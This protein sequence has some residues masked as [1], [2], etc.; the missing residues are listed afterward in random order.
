MR[1]CVGNTFS[2]CSNHHPGPRHRFCVEEGG[3]ILQKLPTAPRRSSLVIEQMRTRSEDIFT[4]F[5]APDEKVAIRPPQDDPLFRELGLQLRMQ[6][7]NLLAVVRAFLPQLVAEAL[8]EGDWDFV[9]EGTHIL[10]RYDGTIV[11]F[12]CV[13]FTMLSARLVTQPNG[14]L[15][16]SRCLSRFFTPLI[17]LITAYRGDV[18]KF[19]GTR[20]IAFFEAFDDNSSFK[21]ACGALSCEHKPDELAC[22]RA[23]ACCHEVNKRLHNFDVGESGVRVTLGAGVGSGIVTVLGVNCGLAASTRDLHAFLVAGAPVDQASVATEYAG[24]FD[25]VLSAQA[26]EHI[27]D[28]VVE[29]STIIE[30]PDFHRLQC[31]DVAQHTYPMIRHAAQQSY[32]PRLSPLGDLSAEDV[33]HGLVMSKNFLHHT[34]VRHVW[35]RTRSDMDEV[36]VVTSVVIRIQGIEPSRE[37]VARDLAKLLL[38]LQRAVHEEEGY[39]LKISVDRRGVLLQFAFGIPPLVHVDDAQ[40]ACRACLQMVMRIRDDLHTVNA[41]VATGHVFCGAIGSDRRCDY[42]IIGEA[43]QLAFDLSCCAKDLGTVLVDKRTRDHCGNELEFTAVDSIILTCSP[44]PALAF[45]LLPAHGEQGGL[46]ATSSGPEQLANPSPRS[47]QRAMTP[48]RAPT[49]PWLDAASTRGERKATSFLRAPMLPTLWTYL[50]VERSPFPPKSSDATVEGDLHWKTHVSVPLPWPARSVACGGVSPL[51]SFRGWRPLVEAEDVFADKCRKGGGLMAITGPFG[52]GKTELAEH[53]LSRAV[54]SNRMQ[55]VFGAIEMRSGDKYTAFDGVIRGALTLLEPSGHIESHEEYR[56]LLMKEARSSQ[57]LEALTKLGDGSATS[58]KRMLSRFHPCSKGLYG[59]GTNPNEL[60]EPKPSHSRRAS[61]VSSEGMEDLQERTGSPVVQL[62]A[63]AVRLIERLSQHASVAVAMRISQGTALLPMDTSPFWALAQALGDLAFARREHDNPH[64]LMVVVV[65]QCHH[66]DTSLDKR[67]TVLNLGPMT[68]VEV[69]RYIHFCLGCSESD[70]EAGQECCESIQSTLEDIVNVDS[71]AEEREDDASAVPAGLVRWLRRI[72]DMPRH[73]E[74]G[75]TQLTREGL[76][77]LNGSRWVVQGSLT[78]LDIGA[79]F[80]THTVGRIVSHMQAMGPEMQHVLQVAVTLTG[81]FSTLDLAAANRLHFTLDMPGVIVLH[82]SVKRLISCNKLVKL[83]FLRRVVQAPDS[84][85]VDGQSPHVPR[86]T[87]TSLLIHQSLRSSW[88][89]SKR[90]KLKRAILLSR[91]LNRNYLRMSVVATEMAASVSHCS[92]GKETLAR[93]QRQKAAL[94]QRGSVGVDDECLQQSFCASLPSSCLVMPTAMP[95][96]SDNSILDEEDSE[97]DSFSPARR[98]SLFSA[99]PSLISWPTPNKI[100]PRIRAFSGRRIHEV[101]V[102]VALCIVLLWPDFWIVIEGPNSCLDGVLYVSASIVFID[103]VISVFRDNSYCTLFLVADIVVLAAVFL[104]MSWASDSSDDKLK[105][106]RKDESRIWRTFVAWIKFGACA[107]RLS[108]WFQHAALLIQPGSAL[109]NWQRRMLGKQPR[110][111]VTCDSE[112]LKRISRQL[113]NAILVSLATFTVLTLVSLRVV[114]MFSHPKEDYSMWAWV[115]LITLMLANHTSHASAAHP[116]ELDVELLEFERFYA[117]MAYGPF[118]VCKGAFDLYLSDFVCEKTLLRSSR[119]RLA[120]P[121]YQGYQL[122][123]ESATIWASFDLSQVT[124]LEAGL[125]LTII[126]LSMLTMVVIA[127]SIDSVVGEVV[128]LP[129][130]RVLAIVRQVAHQLKE[131]LPFAGDPQ[132]VKADDDQD[133]QH[134]DEVTALEKVVSKLTLMV[135]LTAQ[136]TQK[137]AASEWIDGVGVRSVQHLH[138]TNLTVSSRHFSAADDIDSLKMI[139][140]CYEDVNSWGF[141]ALSLE[142]QQLTGVSCWILLHSVDPN[143][144]VD[145]NIF[146][147]FLED[148]AREYH[149]ENPYHNWRHAV[150]CL[151]GVFRQCCLIKAVQCVSTLD[152]FALLVAAAGHDIGH[153]GFSNVFLVQTCHELALRYNDVSPLENMHCSTMFGIMLAKPECNVF[154]TLSHEQYKEARQVCVDTILHT[155][156]RHHFEM[157]KDL[158]M[159]YHANSDAFHCSTAEFPNDVEVELLHH[160]TNRKLALNALLH[161]ADISNTCKP[162]R[163]CS[164]WADLVVNEFFLQG[165]EERRLGIPVQVLND[166]NTVNKPNSQV[167]FIELFVVPFNTALV[168]IFSPLWQLSENLEANLHRW[169]AIRVAEAGDDEDKKKAVNLQVQTISEQLIGVIELAQGKTV[170]RT[171]SPTPLHSMRL[172]MCSVDVADPQATVPSRLY[173]SSPSRSTIMLRH[174]AN[175]EVGQAHLPAMQGRVDSGGSP[176]ASD[177]SS[178]S[179]QRARVRATSSADTVMR[180]LSGASENASCRVSAPMAS[181]SSAASEADLG[182]KDPSSLVSHPH[183]VPSPDSSLMTNSPTNSG[184]PNVIGSLSRRTSSFSSMPKQSP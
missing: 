146:T 136:D 59:V 15:R 128:V 162:W 133:M 49:P 47:P 89:A 90:M 149:N 125:R 178:N 148:I 69:R 1:P 85:P 42:T 43:V 103:I 97:N 153:L 123:V 102:F 110:A 41:G 34:V 116:T 92:F 174:T 141:D 111:P 51:P 173:G 25:T 126:C 152:I 139:G 104:D 135:T 55:P 14:E 62:V 13:G 60:D 160:P 138:H 170:S 166:R 39:L 50:F 77:T 167:A 8:E 61:D 101:L 22:L 63:I 106:R 3:L 27:R 143:F 2:C 99:S 181:Y 184:S 20:L 44:D 24:A 78:E 53:L 120:K 109:H 130:A 18:V 127:A 171:S 177:A 58:Q 140:V 36:R 96:T 147:Q 100:P 179:R 157:V 118:F 158:H 66:L 169:N 71:P 144:N 117:D 57:E 67:H 165:D 7:R 64:P 164:R 76:I 46:R 72:A 154:G 91:G 182:S 161:A 35:N 38:Q 113:A 114:D 19:Y 145:H 132:E 70:K 84:S 79:W 37:H 112:L 94:R 129:L 23:A 168:V 175:M 176:L 156:N 56:A 150:D 137:T 98:V 180:R 10:R 115:Q 31:F 124:Q 21:H 5:V 52:C 16:F 9:P 65:C 54:T 122:D 119:A 142:P 131:N 108:R 93:S 183:A 75:L 87:V 26:W 81:P 88:L 4:R 40:R 121:R 32:V 30:A 73:L 28:F 6:N 134:D 151:H 33:Q 172:R 74:E 45:Q 159:F 17:D 95:D 12:D 105:L 82:H 163:I 11:E 86:W 107:G 83:G 48:P 29:G 80:H 155:D 68:G